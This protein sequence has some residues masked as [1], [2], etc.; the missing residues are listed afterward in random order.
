MSANLDHLL[1]LT[2]REN[3]QERDRVWRDFGRFARL[4]RKALPKRTF[5]FIAVLERQKRGAF[6]IHAAVAGYQNIPL[7]R[8]L[9]HE[10]IGGSDRGNIDVQ[11]FGGQR[12]RLAKYLAKYI[13]KDL[14]E[15]GKGVHRYKRSR[16]IK[17]PEE[18]LL[19]PHNLAL[20]TELIAQFEARGAQVRFHKNRLTQEGAKWLWACSW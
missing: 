8:C 2:Y 19:L 3:T 7:L 16:G 9:W 11:H 1:T 6:H 12:S 4:V 18:V 17:M 10:T 14:A 5:P 13:S 15:A 20:D